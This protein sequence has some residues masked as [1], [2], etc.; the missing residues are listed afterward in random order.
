MQKQNEFE[1]AKLVNNL[2]YRIRLQDEEE[3]RLRLKYKANDATTMQTA[4]IDQMIAIATLKGNTINL[5]DAIAYIVVDYLVSS[6]PGCVARIVESIG[7]DDA[8][9][10]SIV[11]DI[12]EIEKI[13]EI[14]KFVGE[15]YDTEY[16]G[17]NVNSYDFEID[18]NSTRFILK[19]CSKVEVPRAG[20]IFYGLDKV[21]KH[22]ETIGENA[23][24]SQCIALI[25]YLVHKYPV[26][27]KKVL[28]MLAIRNLVS[29]DIPIS[30]KN[31]DKETKSYVDEFIKLIEKLQVGYPLEQLYLEYEEGRTPEAQFVQQ[32]IHIATDFEAGIIDENDGVSP[33]WVKLNLSDK[34]R[35]VMKPGCTWLQMMLW[36]SRKYFNYDENF[37]KLSEAIESQ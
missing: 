24:L 25:M 9:F 28:L 23:F 36:Y 34:V 19:T 1:K 21:F 31:S 11:K 2:L 32:C 22:V 27:I 37:M 20:W 12:D 18:E 6:F 8:W 35:D 3:L 26:N 7:K 30:R 4:F 16:N 29:K 15:V 5:E 14:R 10:M 13:S 33:D 17:F